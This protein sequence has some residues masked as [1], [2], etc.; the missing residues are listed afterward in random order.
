MR[1]R[2][3]KTTGRSAWT[4]QCGEHAPEGLVVVQ[5]S[6]VQREH[7]V[8]ARREPELWSGWRPLRALATTEQ[9]V[10]HTLTRSGRDRRV[11]RER[12]FS[13]AAGSVVNRRSEI[14]TGA[15]VELLGHA[16]VEAPET[17]LH[18]GDPKSTWPLSARRRAWSDISN[19]DQ[20]VGPSATSTGSSRAM[21]SAIC[22]TAP[23]AV[24]PRFTSGS[25]SARSAKKPPT[26][27]RRSAGRVDQR[28]LTLC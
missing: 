14:G 9:R 17:G 21:I 13:L 2:T 25:G 16:P 26:S 15:P 20:R 11:P 7:R 4:A 3:G 18:V 8:L 19:H 5:Y 10:D 12:R 22:A 23:G 6:P 28:V 24:L 27:P 1:G